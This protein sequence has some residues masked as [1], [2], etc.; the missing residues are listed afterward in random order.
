MNNE[1]TKECEEIK[2]IWQDNDKQKEV[3]D[4]NCEKKK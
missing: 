2:R 4:N 3:I 1:L